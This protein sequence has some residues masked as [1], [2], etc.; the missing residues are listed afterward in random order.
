MR[1][2]VLTGVVAAVIV[3]ISA[4][5]ASAAERA[6]RTPPASLG[7]FET[8]SAGT[9]APAEPFLENGETER[10][11]ADFRGRGLVVNLWATWCPPCIKEMPALDRLARA[12][13]ADGIV[14]LPLSSDRGGAEVVGRFY[15]KA[16]ITDLPLIIDDKSRL[17]RAVGATGLPTTVL[18]DAGGREV[19]RVLGV[20]EWDDADT[21][22][23]LR[24]CLA[25]PS[26]QRA[27]RS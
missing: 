2:A 5:H 25:P 20:A 26:G 24:A 8:G 4:A 19:G 21:I 7:D 16:G 22:A 17:T 12:V 27:E 15:A 10:T 14:V 9:A 18:Y 6:C 23:F 13:A 11:L 1:R 3:M